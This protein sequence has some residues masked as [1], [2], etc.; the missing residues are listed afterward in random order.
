MIPS[1]YVPTNREVLDAFVGWLPDQEGDPK[2]LVPVF[3][4]LVT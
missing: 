3:C 2:D 4:D 1:G